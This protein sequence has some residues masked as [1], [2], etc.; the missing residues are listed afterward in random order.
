MNIE[1]F[2]NISKIIER[3]SKTTT[4]K[5]AL[6]RGIIDIIQDNS[7]YISFLENR[8]H[9]PT[10]LL[11]EKW[12]IYYYP[13]LQS[14]MSIPQINGETNLAF[15]NQLSKLIFDYEARGGF[16]AF[17]NDLK[18]KGIPEDLQSDFFELAKKLRD[19]I[20]KMPMKYIGRSITND[21]YSI[22][23]YENQIIRGKSTIDIETLIKEF[24][25]FSIPFEYFE[26]FKIL[27]SFI[28]GQDSILFKWA[29]FSVNASD[30]N[31]SIHEVLNEVL[32]SP[33]TFRDIKESKKLYKEI[34]QKE[35]NVYCVWTGRKIVSYDIDH[36]IPFS[37][38]KNNDLWNLLPS[39][40]K[41]NNQKRD[42]IPTPEIIDRQKNLILEY[43]G[44]I[45][46]SQSKRF[47]KEIQVAL[48]GNHSFDS[49]KSTGISQL[50]NNCNYLIENRG[51][52]GWKI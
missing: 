2:Y 30:N 3:D 33:I 45:F 12:L 19:T 44:I 17:Y 26:A 6:L 49:W 1:V 43:W 24:G 34:L 11:I 10:G 28:N 48:L 50:Q 42:K 35:G 38:W 36:L 9:I 18:N 23:N 14:Q 25:T 39:E 29:E 7:P 46:E 13:I 16:S 27:G 22:F 37:V 41:I 52:E 20:T 5:F 47:Q 40:S 21:F 4:Y 15:R 32:K 8:V 31:L 51:F